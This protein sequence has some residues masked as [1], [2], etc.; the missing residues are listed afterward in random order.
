MPCKVLAYYMTSLFYPFTAQ[1]RMDFQ[2]N[3][4]E[5]DLFFPIQKPR[6]RYFGAAAIGIGCLLANITQMLS[7]EHYYL[8]EIEL[9][10][11]QFR[12]CK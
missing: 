1:C 3:N 6:V 2:L 8:V 5:V 9:P 11:V 10:Q 7:S 12:E 4:L